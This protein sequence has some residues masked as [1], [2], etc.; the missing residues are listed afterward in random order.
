MKKLILSALL[1]SIIGNAS[2]FNH[3]LMLL[4][5]PNP[6]K[7]WEY[8]FVPMAYPLACLGGIVGVSC[9]LVY[10]AKNLLPSENV[11]APALNQLAQNNQS[12]ISANA[13]NWTNHLAIDNSTK[14]L[15]AGVGLTGLSLYAGYKESQLKNNKTKIKSDAGSGLSLITNINFGSL[16]TL[17]PLIPAYFCFKYGFELLRK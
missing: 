1:L 4:Q 10:A 15:L 14:L 7:P 17:A 2:G 3:L 5:R 9:A 11:A 16:Y 8:E 6:E 12:E 13:F